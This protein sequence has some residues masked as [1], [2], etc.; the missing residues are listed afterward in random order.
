MPPPTTKPLPLTEFPERVLLVRFRVPPKLQDTAA[1]G[2]GGI[3]REGAVC[4]RQGAIVDD[5]A[6]AAVRRI[7][8]GVLPERVLLVKVSVPLL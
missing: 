1:A 2:N 4:E 7:A 3:V 6:A 8:G 5:A